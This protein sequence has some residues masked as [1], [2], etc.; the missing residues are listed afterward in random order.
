MIATCLAAPWGLAP[1]PDGES[2]LVGERTTG[3]ILQVAAGT[4]PALVAQIDGIDASGDGGLLGLALS[5]SYDEDG[6]IYAYVTTD[7]DN[8][9]LR[10]AR[11]DTPKAIFTGIPKRC[12]PQRRPDRL[13]RRSNP[14]RR[15]RRH[16]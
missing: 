10:I 2:A 12:G 13:R 4:E 1:L 7:T 3:R 9:I 16:R 6:L 5:P 15:Y 8:R 11:G 14:V